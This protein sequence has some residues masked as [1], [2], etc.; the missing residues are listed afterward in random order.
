VADFV[1]AMAYAEKLHKIGISP[2]T[3]YRKLGPRDQPIF[4]RKVKP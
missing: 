3:A 4:G 1:Y 2:P